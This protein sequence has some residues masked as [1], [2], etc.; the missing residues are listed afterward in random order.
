MN[1]NDAYAA[2]IQTINAAS[3]LPIVR[4]DRENNLK[5]VNILI[6]F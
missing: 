2:V 4:V 6:G 3:Q 1:Q 5:I